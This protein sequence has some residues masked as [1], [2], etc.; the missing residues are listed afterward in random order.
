M[1]DNGN[2]PRWYSIELT[3]D[4][5]DEVLAADP[6]LD[7]SCGCKVH[8]GNGWW[9][10]ESRDDS[11]MLGI[12]CMPHASFYDIERDDLDAERVLEMI[13]LDVKVIHIMTRAQIDQQRNWERQGISTR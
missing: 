2:Y 8:D 7:A 9:L 3:Q 10:V 11:L 6:K 13:E 1:Q 4:G 5:I 12:M